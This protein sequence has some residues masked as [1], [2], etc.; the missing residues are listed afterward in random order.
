MTVALAE[1]EDDGQYD[2]AKYEAP[3][4]TPEADEGTT[5]SAEPVE[6]ESPV[7]SAE[8]P[9][10]PAEPPVESPVQPAV[11][12]VQP[13]ESPVESPV[14]PAVSP[15]QPALLPVQTSVERLSE[16]NPSFPA[17]VSALAASTFPNVP[18]LVPFPY[19][20]SQQ[21]IF[22]FA[23]QQ[24]SPFVSQQVAPFQPQEVAPFIY[25]APQVLRI[26]NEAFPSV[27]A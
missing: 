22:P 24:I 11:S 2:P 1:V 15:V 27:T 23:P 20:A 12:P 8:S 18:P 26:A 16:V 3:F 6:S 13:A 25:S 7:Q 19:L 10:Q 14:Q 4:M 9:V 5:E 21:P 17:S